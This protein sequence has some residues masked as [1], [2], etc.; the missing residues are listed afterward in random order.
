MF[1]IGLTPRQLGVGLQPRFLPFA[2]ALLDINAT[3][4]SIHNEGKS[5]VIKNPRFLLSSMQGVNHACLSGML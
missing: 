3:Q 4:F 5:E 1:L 2:S